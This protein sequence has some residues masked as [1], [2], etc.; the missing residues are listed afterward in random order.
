VCGMCGYGFGFEF[1]YV[2]EF[3]GGGTGEGCG[4]LGM[5]GLRRARR[6]RRDCTLARLGKFF[7]NMVRVLLLRIRMDELGQA[8]LA[9]YIQM[10]MGLLCAED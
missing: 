4:E 1:E 9:E 5:V 8:C 6:A 10:W 2:Y 3:G 7:V